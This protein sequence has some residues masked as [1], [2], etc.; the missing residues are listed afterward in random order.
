MAKQPENYVNDVYMKKWM[1]M[2]EDDNVKRKEQ[3]DVLKRKKIE[4]KDFL[5]KQMHSQLSQDPLLTNL[6]QS[7]SSQ[8]PQFFNV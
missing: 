3:E 1:Q 2:A 5:L 7:A 4:V 8:S 6:N